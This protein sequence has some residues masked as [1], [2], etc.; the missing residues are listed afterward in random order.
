M[1]R[2]N[3]TPINEAL[4]SLINTIAGVHTE[5]LARANAERKEALALYAR[6]LETH[7]DLVEFNAMIGNAA[8]ALNGIDEVAADI[9]S[10]V[11]D[12]L[13][14]GF[15]MIPACD[16]EDFV[17]FCE[18]CGNEITDEDACSLVN[19]EYYHTKCA[20]VEEEDE[21]ADEVA[22]ETIDASQM[23]I[24]DINA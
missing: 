11:L 14:G 2:T 20:P 3:F 10:K 12:V 1:A 6:M 16:Y 7:A 22:D 21:V 9:G 8:A 18:G 17:G 13:D 15:N 23:T 24:D 5:I 19:G 4:N